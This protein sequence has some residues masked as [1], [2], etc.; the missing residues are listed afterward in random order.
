MKG[1][2]APQSLAGVSLGGRAECDKQD[3]DRQ[4]TLFREGPTERTERIERCRADF[5]GTFDS[6]RAKYA[7]G[8]FQVFGIAAMKGSRKP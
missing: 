6:V 5:L 2:A 8:R 4:Q 1:V 7:G 3:D